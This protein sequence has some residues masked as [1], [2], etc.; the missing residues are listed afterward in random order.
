VPGVPR[1]GRFAAGID[2]E[3]VSD[4]GGLPGFALLEAG[5]ARC[6]ERL[7]GAL[8]EGYGVALVIDDVV[9]DGCSHRGSALEAL[10]AERLAPEMRSAALLPPEQTVPP[11]PMRTPIKL[12]VASAVLA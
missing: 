11:V 8:P 1:V 9:R 5:M 10:A 6:A 7:Q 4:I 2:T 12:R 3:A